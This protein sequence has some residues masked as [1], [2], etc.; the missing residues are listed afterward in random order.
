[1][2]ERKNG[3]TLP[4]LSLLVAGFALSQAYRT[5][6]AITVPGLTADFAASARELGL[7]AATFHLAFAAIQ[8]PLGVALD[9]F[10]PRR[11]A[12]ILGL[13]SAV[14]SGLSA[15][16]PNMPVLLVGQALVGIGCAPGLLGT[17]VYMSRTIEPQR[18]ARVSGV[19]FAAGGIG[20]LATATPLAWLVD[21]TNWRAPFVVLGILSLLN[22]LAVLAVVR[23]PP[24]A[25]GHRHESLRAAVAGIWE[26][27]RQRQS[28]G[29][30]ALG[31]VS[32]GTAMTVRGLWVVPLFTDRWHFSLL[33]NGNL[34]L[35]ISIVM[36]VMPVP[37]GRADPGPAR[38][39]AVIVGA[40]VATCLTLVG[41]ALGT[42][43]VAIDVAVALLFAGF[44]S[45]Q[46]LQYADVQ[47]SYPAH[48]TGRAMA[49]FNSSV[50]LG[51]A[52]LQ[53]TS[54][55]VAQ[56]AGLFGWPVLPAVFSWLAVAL[57]IGTLLFAMLPRAKMNV[58]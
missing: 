57:A 25:P 18:F 48:L 2:L 17:M 31:L 21:V 30:I 15:L 42:G 54:G 39:A 19:V 52:L 13:V 32:Y 38:R 53:A 50:F 44:S 33:E 20:M 58:R 12:S 10:G 29:I 37:F 28:A 14:G 34:M 8:I 26:V 55:L 23:D 45:F 56:E 1:M 43:S 51:V 16:A 36:L 27:L 11:V 7:Y 40:S 5:L 22:A 35:A 46:V 9:R 4:A 41:L 47:S 6:A 49:S 3:G 24:P